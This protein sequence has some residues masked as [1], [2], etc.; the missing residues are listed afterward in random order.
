MKPKRDEKQGESMYALKFMII[1]G[2]GVVLM[3]VVQWA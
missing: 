2:G 3:V 1:S